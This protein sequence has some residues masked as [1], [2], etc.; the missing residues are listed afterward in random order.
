[1][2]AMYQDLRK[3][4]EAEAYFQKS[5]KAKPDYFEP[6]YGLGF[7]YFCQGK[8]DQALN[9]FVEAQKINPSDKRPYL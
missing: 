3:F 6:H 7:C 4:S 2:A 1:M 9:K 8:F 5:I